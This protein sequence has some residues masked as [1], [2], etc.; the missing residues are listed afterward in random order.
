[1]KQPPAIRPEDYEYLWSDY[2]VNFIFTSCYLS[3]VFKRADIVLIYDWRQKEL[4][5]FLSSM[6]QRRIASETAFFYQDQGSFDN[7]KFEIN[8]E[9]VQG[10]KLVRKTKEEALSLSPFSLEEL[11]SRFRERAHL[12]QTLVD[13]YFCTEF[14]AVN[15]AE[16]LVMSDEKRY[17]QLKQNLK[18]MGEIKLQARG[19]LNQFYNFRTVFKPYA[20]EMGNRLSRNDIPWLSVDEISGAI[21]GHTIPISKRGKEDWVL[22]K[23]L[24]WNLLKGK[25]AERLSHS[26]DQ[27]FFMLKDTSIRGTVANKGAYK[28]TAK[29]LRTVFSDSVQKEVQKVKKGDV[30]VA[31]TTGPELMVACQMAGAIVTD[32][33]GLTSHAAIISRE[34]N[35]PCIVGTKI[36]TQVL[37]DGDLVEVDADNG[38][39]RLLQKVV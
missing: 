37:R 1:M 33:G 9:I 7:W 28:G 10:E 38:I 2:E 3:P 16:Q 20:D 32:Q 27:H 31:S 5:F 30:L 8:E 18:D 19:L 34:L 39:V 12:F 14:F 11:G 29:V 23:R 21:A 26:F 6:D 36:T 17:R 15:G 22:A 24:D 13:H 4:K 25:E 35:I